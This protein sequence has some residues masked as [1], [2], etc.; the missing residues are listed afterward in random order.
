MVQ[1]S[2]LNEIL[3]DNLIPVNAILCHKNIFKK[4]GYFDPRL[5]DFATWEFL[6]RA[7]KVKDIKWYYLPEHLVCDRQ[8]ETDLLFGNHLAGEKVWQ[9]LNFGEKY[10]S[11]SEQRLSKKYRYLQLFTR[12]NQLLAAKKIAPVC[13]IMLDIVKFSG[14]GDRLWLEVLNQADLEHKKE[15][16]NFIVEFAQKPYLP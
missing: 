8:T 5:T 3:L 11:P 1:Q 13:S 7:S 6:R 16:Y 4:I 9:V 10:C 15:L 14:L 12:A 2:F